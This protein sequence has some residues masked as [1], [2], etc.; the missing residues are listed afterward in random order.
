VPRADF[1][2]IVSPKF[3]ADP[4]RVVCVLARRLFEADEPAL[5][6][7]ADEGQAE[8]IERRLWDFQ[9]DAFVPHQIAGREAGDARCPVLIVPPGV[10]AP[11]RAQVINLR[12]AEVPG[13]FERVLEVVPPD[14]AAK[15]PLRARWK[16]YKARGLELHTHEL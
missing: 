12:D 2:L 8:A 5:I 3:A 14:E 6:L 15:I 16:A 13:G 9:P 1:Y 11:A 10:A 4:L 7:T